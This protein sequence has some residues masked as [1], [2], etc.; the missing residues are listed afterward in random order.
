MN[1][2]ATKL[3]AT[4]QAVTVL[5]ADGNSSTVEATVFDDLLALYRYSKVFGER[6]SKTDFTV[7]YVPTGIALGFF[8]KQATAKAYI[9]FLLTEHADATASAQALEE[10]KYALRRAW[11]SFY[12]RDFPAYPVPEI[13]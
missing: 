9:E 8:R 2:V 4:K 1:F 13:E 12:R 11:L 3:K 6:P 5:K 10:N 7:G